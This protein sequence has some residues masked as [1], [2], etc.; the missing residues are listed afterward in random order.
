MTK[1]KN[2]YDKD[3]LREIQ[4][5]IKVDDET[6]IAQE[7]D[8]YV[9]TTEI[10]KHL[11]ELFDAYQNGLLNNTTKVGVWI[12]GFFGSGKSH[13][14]K[15]VSHLLENKTVNGKKAVEYF[16][17]KI[18]DT[19]LKQN[20]KKAGSIDTDVILFNIDSKSSEDTTSNK[21]K[22]LS[23]FEKVFNEKLGLSTIPHVAELER[24]FIKLNK[25]DEFK[26]IFS[27]IT[28]EN[29]SDARND[30]YFK[31]DEIIESYSKTLGKSKDE[32]EN[33]FD[34]A[35][36]NYDISIEKFSER[37]KEYIDI[38]GGKRNVVFLVD[39]VGQYIGDDNS[40]M[41]NL[42]TIVEN[43]GTKCK[44][45][46]WVMV[47]AQEA[48]DDIIK[49]KGVGFSKIQGRFDTK[50]SLSS[51][52]ISEVI[53]KRI[54]VKNE[55]ASD[56]LEIIYE[57]DEA[58]I[59]NLLSFDKAQY[60]HI[61]SN[62]KD[63]VDTYPFIG[64][65]FDLLQLVFTDIRK[66]GYAGKHLSSGE[67]SLL[68]AIQKT[69]QS[70]K[71]NNIE[72][73][74]PFYA[75]FDTI[76][77]F[78]DHQITNVFSKAKNF[79]KYG[80]LQDID[81][82]ILKMLFMLKNLKEIP[83][84]IDNL[85]TLYVSNINDDKLQIKSQILE[86]L[87]RLELQTLIQKNNDEY[88]FL[89]D[90]EQEINR[91]IKNF[92]VDHARIADY[93]KKIIYE[94]IYN[95][96]KYMFKGNPFPISKFLDDVSY[97]SQYDIGMKVYI[98]DVN[99]SNDEIIRKSSFETNFL[100]VKLEIASSI[101]D[102]IRN[103]IQVE[104]FRRSKSGVS[105][106]Q[107]IE[108]ILKNKQR[109][110]EKSEMHIT[111]NIKEELS[112]A[113]IYISGDEQ[114]LGT[115]EF[116]TRVDKAFETL[117]RNIFSKLI[118]IDVKHDIGDVRK[119]FHA[120][121]GDTLDLK[122]EDNPKA[123]DAMYDYV[124]EK[125]N[126]RETITIR[127]LLQDF[128]SPPYGYSEEDILY[129]ITML[130]KDGLISLYFNHTIQNL[131]VEET[132]TK[133]TN[134]NYHE[135]TIVK[136]KEKIDLSLIND[137]KNVAT[138]AY[139]VLNLTSDESEIMI[140]FKEKCFEPT[141]N[142]LNTIKDLYT[143]NKYPGLDIV[144]SFISIQNKLS[145]IKDSTVFINEVLSLKED[146]TNLSKKFKDITSFF[147]GTQKKVFD[148]TLEVIDN[149][150]SSR[151]YISSTTD[152]FDTVIEISNIINSDTVFNEIQ[153]LAP[154]TVKVNS[155]LEQCYNDSLTEFLSKVDLTVQ[156]LREDSVKYEIVDEA[157]E[158]INSLDSIVSNVKET[159][160]LKNLYASHS[161]VNRV[162]DNFK[163]KIVQSMQQDDTP[164]IKTKTIKLNNLIPSVS[165]L[166]SKEE[167]DKFVSDLKQKLYDELQDQDVLIIN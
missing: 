80:E 138:Y 79:V 126:F 74:I 52:D 112:K 92:T 143:T 25:Y 56:E 39:E 119:L 114:D 18:N 55:S 78:L 63:F 44:G 146:L 131:G 58:V 87:R 102:D 153:K 160:D 59:K 124:L 144:N 142:K 82:N 54:L 5:V 2:I 84:N 104:E 125:N 66:H 100:F 150:N 23:V 161:R 128:K 75:F 47:T 147:A 73:L 133:I 109:E 94:K 71:D 57:K 76:E 4:G 152:V 7:L 111:N 107:Q 91:E 105:L 67:R 41:L 117:V 141:L 134:R 34:K 13:F 28:N 1:L 90:E 123:K 97:S 60:Q 77:K 22:I 11:Y 10:L 86:S 12:S 154:L 165:Q 9:V 17:D 139:D 101:R 140:Q 103:I 64:Y 16:D 70:F 3:I 46:A 96:N 61:Y 19:I 24:Y 62:K 6:F 38:N 113:T 83:S 164:D 43:L 149:F 33:W 120:R 51:S 135:N 42:Q 14:L 27:N 137:M 40:L 8:E 93:Y 29:W 162:V 89:T 166:Q 95:D 20:I 106:S 130:L 32:A 115:G 156:A 35:E 158:S 49:V 45:K 72:T 65:Q 81:V 121:V 21:N 88:K 122:L 159:K 116:R 53:K 148:K 145:S 26:S 108:D 132:L 69:A 50:L 99:S 36:E 48:I 98:D 167:I 155:S 31:R 85:T 30:F 37:V 15:I 163:H 110:I 136:I 157:N 118:Y 127:R 129:L 151:E 68:G